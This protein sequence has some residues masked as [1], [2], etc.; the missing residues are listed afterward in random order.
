MRGGGDVVGGRNPIRTWL[1][2]LETKYYLL[3]FYF[4]D[5]VRERTAGDGD[6]ISGNCRRDNYEIST[7]EN[8][9]MQVAV[10]DPDLGS[11]SESGTCC[12]FPFPS[13]RTSVR[14]KGKSLLPLL[15]FDFPPSP[16]PASFRSSS[17]QES[18]NS[19]FRSILP[20]VWAA[21]GRFSPNAPTYPFH[22]NSP[23]N[24][25]L[26]RSISPHSLISSDLIIFSQP[27]SSLTRP[28]PLFVRRKTLPGEGVASF[29]ALVG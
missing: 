7:G 13:R 8:H 18:W 5:Y 24:P 11:L 28:L 1:R 27:Q 25:P 16:H 19:T 10:S 21:Q 3:N 20:G 17:R 14:Y 6:V 9:P 12:F 2:S 22:N 23:L 4:S 26:V 15:P 29:M